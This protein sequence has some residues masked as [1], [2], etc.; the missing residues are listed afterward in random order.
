MRRYL[1]K[2]E[3]IFMRLELA[4]PCDDWDKGQGGAKEVNKASGFGYRSW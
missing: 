4:G 2:K 1:T 3:E